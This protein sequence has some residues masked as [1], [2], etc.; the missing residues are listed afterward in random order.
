MVSGPESQMFNCMI[1]PL[2]SLPYLGGGE[3]P[4]IFTRGRVMVR[5]TASCHPV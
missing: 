2:F 5:L 4:Q 3:N 1:C